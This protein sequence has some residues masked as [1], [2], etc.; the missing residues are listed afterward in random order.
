MTASRQILTPSQ[1]VTKSRRYLW[2]GNSVR[3]RK[4]H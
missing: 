3:P 4:S 2:S 1:Y